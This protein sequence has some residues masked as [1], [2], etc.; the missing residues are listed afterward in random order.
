MKHHSG[1]ME[2]KYPTLDENTMKMWLI[3]YMHVIELE[4]ELELILFRWMWERGE[5]GV[6]S[7]QKQARV[8]ALCDVVV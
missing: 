6:D 1:G 5:K 2:K 8:R 4:L 7:L 3:V